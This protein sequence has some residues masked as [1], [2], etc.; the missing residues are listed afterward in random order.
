MAVLKGYQ[1]K[2][3]GIDNSIAFSHDL[4]NEA[5]SETAETYVYQIIDPT[6]RLLD[7]GAGLTLSSATTP[8]LDTSW[9]DHGIDWLTGRVK[10]DQTGLLDLTASGKYFSALVEIGEAYNWTVDLSADVVD[11]SAFG[12]EWK[13]KAV[14]QKSWTG[15]FEKFTIDSYWF[16]IMKL[17]KVF[18]VKFYT[19]ANKGYQ[20]FCVIPGLSTG[21]SVT[22][23]I[24][25]TVNLESH[26]LIEEFTEA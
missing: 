17:G 6:K 8:T 13:K 1:A 19:E 14:T 2:V 7:P 20:G 25:E 4:V 5:M 11:V 15:S 23:V 22:D 10:V 26:W 12:D 9:K 21:A 18:L 3:F 16:D 24:K